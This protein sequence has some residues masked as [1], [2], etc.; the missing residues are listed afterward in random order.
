MKKEGK[1]GVLFDTILTRLSSQQL[2]KAVL[3]KLQ[4]EQNLQLPDLIK[5]FQ[6]AKQEAQLPLS[7]FS[8]SLEPAE[9]LYKFLKEN[10]GFSFQRIAQ[11]MKRDQKSIWATY[12][13]AQERRNQKFLVKEEKYLLPLSIF[14]NRSYSFLESV[15]FYLN[16]AYHL[17]NKE[18]AKLL[19]KTPNT[20]AVLMKRARD[21]H[22]ARL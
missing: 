11:T 19:R 15:V 17:S 2:L 14:N 13:R 21:K 1:E 9:A 6:E 22:E 16:S 5:T 7:I 3:Q 8:H 12:Q 4:Q 20:I 18:I 10:E